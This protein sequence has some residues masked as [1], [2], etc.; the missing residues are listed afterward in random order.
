MIVCVC[1]CVS[2][3]V[4]VCNLHCFNRWEMNHTD[5]FLCF[6]AK[7]LVYLI[8]N[9]LS[10]CTSHCRLPIFPP[11]KLMFLLL[12][13]RRHFNYKGIIRKS[14]GTYFKITDGKEHSFPALLVSQVRSMSYQRTICP[15][16]GMSRVLKTHKSAQKTVS[17]AQMEDFCN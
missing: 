17:G 6:S 9:W 3:C 14:Q 15:L 11:G 7:E 5:L 8:I 16:L 1:M 13:Y 4:C 2:V 12:I 10:I